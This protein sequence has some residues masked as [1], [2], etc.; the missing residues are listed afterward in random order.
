[1]GPQMGKRYFLYV[2]PVPIPLEALQPVFKARLHKGSLVSSQVIIR[3]HG[4]FEISP[5]RER[6]SDKLL[7][8]TLHKAQKAVPNIVLLAIGSIDHNGILSV[9]CTSR[10][11]ITTVLAREIQGTVRDIGLFSEKTVELSHIIANELLCRIVVK[12]ECDIGTELLEPS[13]TSFSGIFVIN[14]PMRK[15]MVQSYLEHSRRYSDAVT[16]SGNTSIRRWLYKLGFTKKDVLHAI[17]AA[18]I[19]EAAFRVIVILMETGHSEA[20]E[21]GDVSDLGFPSSLVQRLDSDSS[22]SAAEMASQSHLGEFEVVEILTT[23]KKL[24][25]VDIVDRSE[26]H[27]KP[28]GSKGIPILIASIHQVTEMAPLRSDMFMSGRKVFRTVIDD[29]QRG[30]EPDK[31]LVN[32]A[33]S[34]N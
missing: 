7:R 33:I 8:S 30:W 16:R 17:V 34:L 5:R 13:S 2:D 26:R 19:V 23:L 20:R 14:E 12:N 15:R 32:R 21:R 29:E 22:F 1:M 25:I 6:D 11:H 3:K 10:R 4:S 24:G 27:Y 9:Y 18:I 28:T 31:T